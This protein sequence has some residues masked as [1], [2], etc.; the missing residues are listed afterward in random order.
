MVTVF[1]HLGFV[2]ELQIVQADGMK[3]HHAPQL[4]PQLPHRATGS[5]VKTE[6]V[7]RPTG[8]VMVTTIVPMDP[9]SPIPA[10]VTGTNVPMDTVSLMVGSVMGMK[11]VT[12][13]MMK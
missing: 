10:R 4:Q 8:S 13:E 7:L 6:N 12:Q 11:I 3:S 1:L 9:M 5:N 2:T